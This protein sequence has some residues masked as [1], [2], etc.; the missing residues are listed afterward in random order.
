M[1]TVVFAARS[2]WAIAYASG[3]NKA[4]DYIAHLSRTNI[5]G[6]YITSIV[7]YGVFEVSCTERERGGGGMHCGDWKLMVGFIFMFH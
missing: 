1:Y 2:I 5:T 4:Q 7:F 6:L 3:V